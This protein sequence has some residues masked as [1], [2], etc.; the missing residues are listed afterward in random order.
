MNLVVGAGER[1]VEQPAL[2]G[3]GGLGRRPTDGHQP[4]LDPGEVH[5]P[6]LQTLGCVE[7]GD[8]DP[9]AH[10]RGGVATEGRAH[11]RH[12][13]GT[14]R[15]RI[16]DELL[17]GET[18]ERRQRRCGI[19]RTLADPI[20]RPRLGGARSR[21]VTVDVVP[22]VRQRRCVE[23]KIFEDDAQRVPAPF[24]LGQASY[25][26]RVLQQAGT[27]AHPEGDLRRG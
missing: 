3:A 20:G 25:D 24:D 5:H 14:G 2:F 1:H 22:D 15:L 7:G 18:G 13:P 16:D 11:P 4:V 27:V 6:P 26:H 19:A 12:E 8:L 21:L 23:P 17:L 9:V 10:H